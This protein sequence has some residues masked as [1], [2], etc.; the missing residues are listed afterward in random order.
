[1]MGQGE[2]KS[3]CL[4]LSHSASFSCS[5][6]FCACQSFWFQTDPFCQNFQVEAEKYFVLD[7]GVSCSFIRRRNKE[8]LQDASLIVGFDR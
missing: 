2:T 7:K 8:L 5:F 4:S 1:M 3:T 6:V